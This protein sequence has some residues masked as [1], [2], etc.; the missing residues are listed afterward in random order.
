MDAA[1]ITTDPLLVSK[2]TLP[3]G[4]GV[5]RTFTIKN[6]RLGMRVQ[7]YGRTTGFTKGRVIGINMTVT[8]GYNP[9]PAKF[10]NQ[11]EFRG[12][13]GTFGGPGDSGSLIVTD[14]RFPIALLFAGAGQLVSGNPIQPI[15]D[16][17]RMEIDG[18]DSQDFP[19]PGKIGEAQPK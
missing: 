1:V 19:V 5:P 11:I 12:V 14:D 9:G 17:F 16:E 10:V 4:Y 8:V 13:G 7:K 6:A 3:D 15:L 2:Q 18:D